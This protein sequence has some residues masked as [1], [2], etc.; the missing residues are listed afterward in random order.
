MDPMTQAVFASR[1]QQSS[2]PRLEH[3][4]GRG[5][6]EGFPFPLSQPMGTNKPLTHSRNLDCLDHEA[7]A[8]GQDG[9]DM[10]ILTASALKTIP[11]V[12]GSMDQSRGLHFADP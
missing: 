10:Q 11:M 2:W 12:A 8:K 6:M 9:Q 7:S 4:K 5:K 1:L 3:S